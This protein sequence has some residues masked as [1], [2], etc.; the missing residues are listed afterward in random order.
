M[1]VIWPTM[2]IYL[3]M[4]SIY[5]IYAIYLCMISIYAICYISMYDI[6]L[7]YLSMLSINLSI[8]LSMNQSIK[9]SIP[10]I[11]L[12]FPSHFMLL[13][14]KFNYINFH[15]QSHVFIS[16]YLLYFFLIFT[17]ILKYQSKCPIPMTVSSWHPWK[18]KFC[19]F[20]A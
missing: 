8:Y 5:A 14:Q 10:S 11:F 16:L 19:R 12:S 18:K 17:H 9:L 20:I 3:Y 4:I 15:I 1:W 2:D 6:Y 7:C 13:H